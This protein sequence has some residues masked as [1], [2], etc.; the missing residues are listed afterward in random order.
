MISSSPQVVNAL[1]IACLEP[2]CM[3][4]TVILHDPREGIGPVAME[5]FARVE[6]AV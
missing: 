2:I 5:A 3:S 4:R 1:I 6:F